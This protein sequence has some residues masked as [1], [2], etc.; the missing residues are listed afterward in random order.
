MTGIWHHIR[1]SGRPPDLT[2]RALVELITDYLEG[3]L[4]AAD[5]VRFETHLGACRGC[6]AYVEQMRTTIALAGR[7]VED[8]LCDDA[9]AELLAAFRDWSR[10]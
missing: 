7:I 4:D 3:A 8:D 5:R 6:A 10:R 2:C 9:R 1:R